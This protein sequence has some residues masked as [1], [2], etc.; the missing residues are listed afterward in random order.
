MNSKYFGNSLDLFKYDI[1]THILTKSDGL[2]LF[3]IPMITSPLPKERNSKYVTYEVGV[4]NKKL[5]QMLRT[6]FEK[7]YSDISLIKSYFVSRG[8]H[9]SMLNPDGP[10]CEGEMMYFDETNRK[11]YFNQAV[12]HYKS[13][14]NNT[15]VYIDPDV[16]SDVGITRRFRSNKNMYV[17]RQE[18][19]QLKNGLRSEDFIAYFQHLGNSNYTVEQRLE[20]LQKSFGE[21]VLF[22]GY[23]RIQAGMVLIFN[24]QESYVVKRKLIEDYFRDYGHLKHRDKF[25]IQG[26]PLTSSGFL[27]L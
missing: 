20:D 10:E 8:V 24:D 15:L 11:E 22:I 23:A 19:I 27:A 3:Y 26:K 4:K 7:E 1:L 14:V 6:E 13:L 21:W 17:R 16:G 18:L 12:R 9:L 25:I 5:F 2:S